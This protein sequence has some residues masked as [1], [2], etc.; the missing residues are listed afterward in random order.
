[1]E[2]RV[3]KTCE[4]EKVVNDFHKG[5]YHCKEC[6]NYQNREKTLKNNPERAEKEKLNKLGMRKCK[7]CNEIKELELFPQ[8]TQYKGEK[9]WAHKCRK[10]RSNERTKKTGSKKQYSKFR[11]ETERTCETCGKTYPLNETYFQP[12]HK[13][14]HAHTFMY[15]CISCYQ[16]E[17]KMWK[18]S[19]S[20]DDKIKMK[21]RLKEWRKSNKDKLLD[22]QRKYNEENREE[23]LKRMRKWRRKNKED[24][25]RKRRLRKEK[26]PLFKLSATIRPRISSAFKA[27]GYTK[28]S[29]TYKL[30]GEEYSTVKK[31]LE[32]KFNSN[33]SWDNHGEWHIDHI[34]PLAS[35]ESEAEL[36][37]LCHFKNLQPMW[38]IEN[39]SKNDDYDPKDKEK[40]LE[41]YSKNVVQK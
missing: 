10:C 8:V 14:K 24:I 22:Y 36:V 7:Y 12:R 28:K 38:A 11:D 15:D 23:V 5:Q 4:V 18:R 32:S 6:L 25:N 1:M 41:W 16:E 2:T 3:C 27:K 17:V 21:D 35:A 20:K 40:Y 26:D 39:M 37:A 29:K 31:F 13:K 30:L 34:I 33:M 19:L 9:R